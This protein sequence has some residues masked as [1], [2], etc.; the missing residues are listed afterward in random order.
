VKPAPFEYVAVHSADEAIAALARHGDEAKILA[1]GQSL[2]P[3]LNLRLARPAVV[4]DINAAGELDY[5][6][7]R[8]GAVVVGALVRQRRLERWAVTRAPLIAEALRF[9]GHPAIRIRGTAAGSIAHADPASELPAILLC[10]EARAVARGQGGERVIPLEQLFVAP[11]TTS[12]GADEL[13]T[14]LRFRVPAVGTGWGFAEVSR[15]HGDFALTGAAS[16]LSLD[17]SGIVVAARV[18]LFGVGPTAV[19]SVPAED[20]LVGREPTPARLREAARAAAAALSPDADLHASADYRRRVAAVLAERAI[21]AAVQRAEPGD[22][23][24]VSGGAIA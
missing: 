8:D 4:V 24:R 11:L 21:A 2:V 13:L 15:R 6:D 1:G 12:L 19:R 18:A 20:A 10:L 14:E 3:M 22:R 16:V 7:E 5:L 17:G 9:V 23:A